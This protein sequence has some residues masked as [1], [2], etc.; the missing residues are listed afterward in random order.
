MISDPLPST[1][2]LTPPSQP[3]FNLSQQSITPTA[4]RVWAKIYQIRKPVSF[5]NLV[6]EEYTIGRSRDADIRLDILEC[7]KIHCT[8]TR[9]RIDLNSWFIQDNST[10]GTFVESLK[11][12]KGEKKMLKHGDKFEIR[13]KN[14]EPML[15]SIVSFIDLQV[16]CTHVK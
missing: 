8:I 1:Q 12:R 7:S 13:N 9:S 14:M 5:F 10:N 3:F 11:L 2:P 6:N 15:L 4:L 16:S